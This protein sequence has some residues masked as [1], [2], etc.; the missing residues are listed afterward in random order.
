MLPGMLYSSDPVLP[1]ATGHTRLMQTAPLQRLLA[2]NS[3]GTGLAS[4]LEG[5]ERNR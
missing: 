1:C 2:E 3:L 4:Y 5:A